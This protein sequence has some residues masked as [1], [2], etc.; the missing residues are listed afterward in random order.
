VR[1]DESEGGMGKMKKV[2]RPNSGHRCTLVLKDI[3]IRRLLRDDES[4]GLF[5]CF[6]S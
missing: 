2:E 4:E 5:G 6:L 1:G 3:K